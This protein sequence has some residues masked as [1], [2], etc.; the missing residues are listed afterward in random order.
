MA[1]TRFVF[2]Y[3]GLVELLKSGGVLADLERRAR[4]VAAAAGEGHEASAVVGKNRA[5][6]SVITAT[7]EARRGEAKDHRLL[8]ALDAAR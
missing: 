8:R 6:A 1:E 5:R 7:A 4:A 2:R 3:E